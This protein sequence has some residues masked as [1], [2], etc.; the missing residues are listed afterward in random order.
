LIQGPY[1]VHP[2]TR[3]APPEAICFFYLSG[4]F[5]YFPPFL[6]FVQL[7]CPLSFG[8]CFILFSKPFSIT[9]FLLSSSFFG[10]V[11]GGRAV[12]PHHRKRLLARIAQAYAVEQPD[13]PR[14]PMRGQA[15]R[16]FAGEVPSCT[17]PRTRGRFGRRTCVG[18]V[19]REVPQSVL[20]YRFFCF[21]TRR[22]AHG[23][24][25]VTYGLWD[26]SMFCR[27]SRAGSRVGFFVCF[28]FCSVS[29]VVRTCPCYLVPCLVGEVVAFL[30]GKPC[31]APPPPG[32]L[33][34]IDICSRFRLSSVRA[35]VAV[36]VSSGR[37]DRL[38]RPLGL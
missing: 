35:R 20:V 24:P 28:L 14:R 29:V 10:C 15:G 22:S 18:S 21:P 36:S 5:P 9:W 11:C 4:L 38:D 13:V 8:I 32:S 6:A 16:T 25:R 19:L 3:R 17:S 34:A 12:G 1:R 33:A 30:G 7:L 27:L 37:F 23:L 26:I 2:L 31:R